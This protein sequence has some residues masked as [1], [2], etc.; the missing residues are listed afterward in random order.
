MHTDPKRPI[1]YRPGVDIEQVRPEYRYLYED[2]SQE[3]ARLLHAKS[4]AD[5][6]AARASFSLGNALMFLACLAVP[7]CLAYLLL[8]EPNR[9]SCDRGRCAN[10]HAM[11][12]LA[13]AWLAF[14]IYVGCRIVKRA[15]FKAS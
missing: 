14:T 15:F 11:G 8:A 4:E 7:A 2:F 10:S 9:L 3:E 5:I 6:Q 12:I 1:K 13:L